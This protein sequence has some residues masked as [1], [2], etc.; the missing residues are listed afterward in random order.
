MYALITGATSGIGRACAERFV[1]SGLGVILV[2]RRAQ[3]LSK[4]KAEI[5]QKYGVSVLTF[6]VDVTDHAAV[7]NMEAELKNVS[8][9]VLVNNA[10]LALGR[11]AF[12][13][14][15]WEDLDQIIAVNVVGF[16]RIAKL[17]LPHII[18]QKGHIFN[19]SSIAGIEAYPGGHVYCA[20]KSFVK[21]LS[22]GLREDLIGTNVRVTDIAPG[23]VETEFSVVRFKGDTDAAKQVYEGFVPLYAK[24]IAECVMAAHNMPQSVN[25]EYMLVMATAQVSATRVAKEAQ[26]V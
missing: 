10:G 7:L 16:T 4:A 8:I 6:A 14:A 11:N 12:Q 23:A 13:D 2:G 21:Q 24:D 25:I 1:A 9:S 17:F 15:A 19:I 22:K 5:E 20:T 18:N 26:R 3:K